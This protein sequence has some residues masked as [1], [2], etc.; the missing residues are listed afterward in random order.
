MLDARSAWCYGDPGVSAVLLKVGSSTGRASCRDLAVSVSCRAARRPFEETGVADASLC[1]GAA[2][3]GHINNR[4]FQA[5]GES[6]LAT[7]ARAW[8]AKALAMRRLGEGIG[9]YLN[10]WPEI[11]EWRAE[12]GFLVGAAGTGLA[13]LSAIYP[14]EPLWDTPLLLPSGSI[15]S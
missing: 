14:V 7:A 6:D 15:L 2:G 3:L 11:S 9:G 8:L 1:H 13:L 5:T 10:W 4:L 12:P